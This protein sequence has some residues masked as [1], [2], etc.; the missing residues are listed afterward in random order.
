MNW[1]SSTGD[2]FVYWSF[3]VLLVLILTYCGWGISNDDEKQTH[4]RK[5]AWIAGIYIH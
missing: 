1:S 5:Y 3:Y 4:F 2:P